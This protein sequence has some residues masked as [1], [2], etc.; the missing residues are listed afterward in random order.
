MTELKLISPLE[1]VFPDVRPTME[2][3]RGVMLR[4]ERHH[5]S[6]YLYLAEEWPALFPVKIHAETVPGLSVR[7]FK[8]ALV[9]AVFG[10]TESDDM[11]VLNE[12]RSGLYPDC[13]MEEESTV[14]SPRKYTGFT[15][16]VTAKGKKA[17]PKGEYKIRLWAEKDGEELCS[18]VYHLTVQN[19]CLPEN[20]LILTQ[21]IHFDSIMHAHKVKAF[22][23]A[24]YR[25]CR[26]YFE[27][28]VNYGQ[29][30]VLTPLFTF[31]L[32]TAPGHRRDPFQLVGVK[33][34]N[35]NYTFDFSELDHFISFAFSC[36]FRY[37]EFSHL[38]SQWGAC[39]APAIYGE[40]NGELKQFFGWDTDSLGEE[41][42]AFL[43]AFLPA[44]TA[45]AEKK[46]LMGKCFLHLSDEPN[47]EHLDRYRQLS[48]FVRA[49]THDIPLLDALSHFEYQKENLVDLA[50]VC[51][52]Q[53]KPFCD[54]KVPHLVYYCCCP[55]VKAYPNRMMA[56]P[57]HRVRILG[58]LLY[59]N[60]A[61]GFLQWGFN[62]YQCALSLYP[63]DP[64][65]TTDA[66][67][68]FPAGDAFIVYPK[69]GGCRPS[70]RLFAFYDGIK[71][72]LALKRLE[73][74]R[75]RDFVLSFLE[76]EGIG[77][78]YNDYPRNPAA[79]EAMR[80]KILLLLEEAK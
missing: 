68:I 49:H 54:A 61:K 35:G 34:E 72:Y 7:L 37:I 43:A 31:A 55:T 50:A 67:G 3:T 60:G 71:D 22:S 76:K 57:L 80:E 74:K 59:R 17:L 6:F 5:F 69:E 73:E 46:G 51:I 79:F 77:E 24:F 52:D 40:E 44:L 18:A 8:T 15:A 30:M 9:P 21:W 1:K 33:K 75:G 58:T 41:Y 56:M 62:F 23:P 70:L 20:D 16:E 12:N 48:A 10:G 13:L 11:Y 42:L 26:S 38:F 4:N 78:G 66:D 63:I 29:T 53:D 32:D 64:Y 14:L 45:F 39:H 36:G 28:A 47:E 25:V 19:E 2:K 27:T 65:K